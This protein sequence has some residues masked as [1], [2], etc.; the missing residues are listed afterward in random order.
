MK[1]KKGY[2]F[3]EK[4][5]WYARITVKDSTGKRRNIKRTA[6]SKADAKKILKKIIYELENVGTSAIDG[7]TMTFNALADYYEKHYAKT[8]KFVENTKIEGLRDLDSVKYY[9]K[10]YRAFFGGKKLREITH[11]DIKEFRTTRLQT[12]TRRNTPRTITTVNRELAYLRRMLN[13]AVRQGWIIRNPFNCGDP[14]IITSC[15]RRRE[16][17][18]TL[19]EEIRL[20][21][22]CTGN[23]EIKYKWKG[24]DVTAKKSGERPTLKALIIALLDTGCRKGEMLKLIWDDVDMDNRVIS[25]RALNTKTLKSRQVAITQ[26][27]YDQLILLWDKSDK[28][29]ESNVFGIS[30]NVSKSFKTACEIAGIKHGGIDGLTLHCLRHTAATRLVQGQLPI[31]MVGRIL[32]HTQVNTTYRYLT[33]TMETAKQAANI[34]ESFQMQPSDELN[35]A[36]DYVN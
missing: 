33:A 22:A 1:D 14:L 7:L 32:G 16:R 9:V 30:D 34:F 31:Q 18:L 23:R 8:A 12:P 29:L 24:K 36:T 20:L 10:N 3:E 21:E 25:I 6:N 15:E 26:R 27:F 4:G 2:V 5:K 11:G 28:S 19:D 35:G 17:I 13:I